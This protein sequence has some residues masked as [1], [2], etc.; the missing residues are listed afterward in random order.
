MSMAIQGRS[1][2]RNGRVAV[3]VAGA[4]AAAVVGL[5]LWITW[6]AVFDDP[7][8]SGVWLIGATLP[9]SVP[10]A[11]LPVSGPVFLALLTGAGLVQAWALWRV[12]RGKRLD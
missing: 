2:Y 4:Y 8:F 9:L 6:L 12:L 1:P 5:V 10:V 11:S 7:G 3:W